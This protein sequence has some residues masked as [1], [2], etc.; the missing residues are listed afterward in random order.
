MPFLHFNGAVKIRDICLFVVFLRFVFESVVTVCRFWGLFLM[1]FW[2]S[3]ICMC[4]FPVKSWDLS[5]CVDSGS[6]SPTTHT[7][8]VTTHTRAMKLKHQ[9][10]RE[11]LE[12][13]ILELKTLCIREAVRIP[14]RCLKFRTLCRTTSPRTASARPSY[15]PAKQLWW[16]KDHL[17]NSSRQSQKHVT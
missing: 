9:D 7:K 3:H 11:K 14:H 16:L 2:F 10:L 6:D 17:N 5:F 4:R 12:R 15:H 13:C 8:D 1:V